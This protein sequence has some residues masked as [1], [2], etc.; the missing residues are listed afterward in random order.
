MPMIKQTQSQRQEQ[1]LL[2]KII[3]KQ[4]MLQVPTFALEEVIMT[5]LEQNPFLELEEE[6]VE[7]NPEEV[8]SENLEQSVSETAEGDES[9]TLEDE[10]RDVSVEKESELDY[11]YYDTSDSEGYKTEGYREK[12]SREVIENVWR[13]RLT[14]SDMLKT[15]LHLEDLS[16]VEMLI[17]EKLIEYIDNNGYLSESLEVILQEIISE[18][19]Q[20]DFES[21]KIDIELLERILKIIQT[22]DPPGVGARNIQESLIIQTELAEEID[23]NLKSLS[24]KVLKNY[25]NELTNKKYKKLKEELKISESEI[26]A[27]YEWITKLNPK[28]GASIDSSDDIYIYPDLIVT[29]NTEGKLIVELN[30]RHIPS[31]RMNRMYQLLAERP[32]GRDRS[33]YKNYYDR[34]KWFLDALRSRRETML[35]VM[36]SIVKRQEEFF[37]TEGAHLKPMYEKDVAED[38]GMDISTVSRTVR[39]K[40]VQTDFG[41]YELK[42]FFSSHIRKDNGEDV[43]AKEIKNKIREFIS[44]E[45]PSNPM[46]DEEL[47]KLLV[48]EGYQ[49]ARRTVTKYR[50][51]MNIPVA[52]LRKKINI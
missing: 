27:I 26:E 21:E 22:F 7:E 42:S 2:P 19:P 10:I 17:G 24:L 34:A 48:Q 4:T 46:S 1:K 11:D 20:E 43:S 39:G 50:E 36:N 18:L 30:D 8:E 13:A 29:E 9:R 3:Q 37:R 5:E 32:T 38:I 49:V 16:E 47:S 25:Y 52:R 40:Y 41:I 35:K 45:D 15:Q 51:S 31:V 6:R 33:F 12:E 23:E 14:L 44:S 28:P